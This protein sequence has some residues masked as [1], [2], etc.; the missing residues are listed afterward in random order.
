[1][2]EKPKKKP[3]AANRRKDS[4]V[5]KKNTQAGEAPEFARR[6]FNRGSNR[7]INN[8]ADRFYREIAQ[9]ASEVS[10]Q[11]FVTDENG[12]RVGDLPWIDA[13]RSME[14]DIR[15]K[16]AEITAPPA[17]PEAPAEPPAE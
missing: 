16:V 13:L 11:A 6:K 14:A 2:A 17:E 12:N 15:V 9:F 8:A 10:L 5:G 3:A 4:P 7:R 1:M